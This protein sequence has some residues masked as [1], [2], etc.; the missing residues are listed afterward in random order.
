MT[1]LPHGDVGRIINSFVSG[2]HQ[3]AVRWQRDFRQRLYIKRK[4]LSFLEQLRGGKG[5]KRK[6]SRVGLGLKII[7]VDW[8]QEEQRKQRRK[9]RKKRKQQR[10]QRTQ[11]TQQ[12]K[13]RR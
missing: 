9:Q 11:R 2:Q 7:Y 10:K 13:Q 6:S 5:R 12:R 4:S 3:D 1:S 8:Y